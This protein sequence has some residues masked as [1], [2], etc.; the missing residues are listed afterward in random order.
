MLTKSQAKGFTLIEVLLSLMVFAMLGLAI[1]SVLSNTI[2]GHETVQSQNNTL[3]ALQRTFAMMEADI[4]QMSQRQ[5]RVD[6]EEPQ[7][8]FLRSGEYMFDSESIGF[9][10]VRD[11]WTNPG[12]VLPRS[13][14]QQVA[15]R[16]IE[17]KLQRLY[18][19]FVDHESGTEPKVQNLVLGVSAI[20]LQY[21]ANDEWVDELDAEHIP[22]LLKVGIETETYGLIERT[23]P[24]I[25]TVQEQEQDELDDGK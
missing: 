17:N 20:Q 19:N 15:Y 14:L 9:G 7:K 4:V 1:Y 23:F 11:G 6:G 16:V 22:S 5:V 13:E 24:L 10:F 18:F 3:T 2:K 25:A 8:V 21:F 12:L